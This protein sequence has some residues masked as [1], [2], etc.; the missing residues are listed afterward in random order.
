M[1]TYKIRPI[2]SLPA[3]K[4]HWG[5]TCEQCRALVAAVTTPADLSRQSARAILGMWPEL[6]EA[7]GIHERACEVRGE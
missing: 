7:V 4:R 2:A 6:R 3:A 1:P 5:L